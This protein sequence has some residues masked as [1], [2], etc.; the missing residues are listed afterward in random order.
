MFPIKP[1]AP[2]QGIGKTKAPATPTTSPHGDLPADSVS[3]GRCPFLS[4]MGA[5]PVDTASTQ[6]PAVQPPPDTMIEAPLSTAGAAI[7]AP[8]PEV[9]PSLK[10]LDARLAL[11]EQAS[12][13]ETP[14]TDTPRA[15]RQSQTTTLQAAAVVAGPAAAVLSAAPRLHEVPLPKRLGVWEFINGI[16]RHRV[17]P[18][19]FFD[20]FHKKHGS[21]FSVSL[22]TGHKYVFDCRPRS[23]SG[24]LVHTDS[25]DDS[26]EKPPLQGHGLAFLLGT[27]NVFLGNGE[28]WK[29]AHEVMQP[30]LAPP[31]IN[32]DAMTA[33]VTS[34]LD[35]HIDALAAKAQK[36]PVEV[37][38]RQ[39]MQKATL[40]VALR[41]LLGTHL[42]KT[43]L[44]KVQN[45]FQVS[46]EWLGRE[47][48][49][50]TDFSFSN[51]AGIL[52]GASDLK[53]AYKTLTDLGDRI[54]ADRRASGSPGTDLLGG[55]L[56]ARDPKTG[57]GFSDERLRNEV[58]TIILAGHETTATLLSWSTLMLA[59][60][61][62][63]YK[64]IQH[65]VD[66]APK[67][68]PTFDTLKDLTTVQ[69][70]VKE[71]LR[72][73]SPAYFLVRRAKEDTKLGPPQQEMPIS[74]GTHVVMSVFHA[75]RDEET[76]GVKKTGFPASGFH[77]QRFRNANP[78][79]YPFGGGVRIC[80]GIHLAKLEANVM[81]TQ[82]AKRFD[83]AAVNPAPP[84]I[85]SDISV[86]PNDARV[87]LT[88]RAPHPPQVEQ[89]TD[90]Q[91]ARAKR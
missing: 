11:Y 3:L 30:H 72:L 21:T 38:M 9:P 44:G 71:T 79:M 61:P 39:V 52:P 64:E 76:Y 37:D 88:L 1:D 81:L 49:N 14:P 47:T 36:G 17:S 10:D 57:K 25:A 70:A 32:A 83:M 66:A 86:H 58:L 85:L 22:P 8:R 78:K 12:A 7:P 31:A 41:T 63:T 5:A 42:S 19:G 6:A 28:I 87:R 68:A 55:L 4:S 74:K 51:F 46:M 77:P 53:D 29:Q 40:D 15:S 2:L 75:H 69:D 54:I 90:A 89:P 56:Q 35:E 59:R 16:R 27:D 82:M 62:E 34:I 65:Q 13:G 80:M 48:L 84:Q 50:P 18:V 24:P 33:K 67:G 23:L 60:N 26:W 43:E 91:T 73:Y 45:A 20:E